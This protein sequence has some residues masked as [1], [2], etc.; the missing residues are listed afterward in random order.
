MNRGGEGGEGILV[1]DEGEGSLS[2]EKK[3]GRKEERV[4]R[5]KSGKG[6]WVVEAV[7]EVRA[8]GR[9]GGDEGGEGLMVE[10]EGEGVLTMLDKE[11][12]MDL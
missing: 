11:E 2:V 1:R 7:E 6:C 10:G 12:L 4:E 9:D 8:V 5:R 3:K